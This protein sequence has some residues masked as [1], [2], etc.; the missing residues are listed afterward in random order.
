M[1]M[2]RTH[3]VWLSVARAFLPDGSWADYG[4]ADLCREHPATFAPVHTRG[5]T[6]Q[7]DSVLRF[8]ELR[9]ADNSSVQ[10]GRVLAAPRAARA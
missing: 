10:R 8:A 7:Q 5:S 1:A 6:E 2:W 3:R 4:P 9:C